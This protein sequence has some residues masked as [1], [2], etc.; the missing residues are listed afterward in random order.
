VNPSVRP[1][2]E[3][4]ERT[5][6]L[7]ED[8]VIAARPPFSLDSEAVV[9]QL[10]TGHGVPDE[11]LAQGFEYFLESSTIEEVLEVFKG[12]PPTANEKRD[13]LFHY[14]VYDGFPEWVYRR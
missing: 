2:R 8:D 5:E 7:G 12:T 3:L 11:I 14:G 10:D 1:L 6:A 9:A 13:L 4:L